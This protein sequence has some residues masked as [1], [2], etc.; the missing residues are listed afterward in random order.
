MAQVSQIQLTQPVMTILW[1]ALLLAE[2]L[3]WP[4]ALGA[5]AVVLFAALSVRTRLTP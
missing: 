1:A 5:L 4:T 3:T 2:P